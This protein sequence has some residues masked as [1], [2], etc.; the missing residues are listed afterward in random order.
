MCNDVTRDSD[1]AGYSESDGQLAA[2]V[3]A[4]RLGVR[5]ANWLGGTEGSDKIMIS[6]SNDSDSESETASESRSFKQLEHGGTAWPVFRP[7]QADSKSGISLPSAPVPG[8]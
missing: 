6:S 1:G 3:T 2:T 5:P 4:L 8:Q 7:G